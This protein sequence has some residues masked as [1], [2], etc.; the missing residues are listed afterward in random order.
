MGH[1]DYWQEIISFIKEYEKKDINKK[2]YNEKYICCFLSIWNLK[3]AI[4]YKCRRV[5]LTRTSVYF[6]ISNLT[7]PFSYFI[8]VA[9]MHYTFGLLFLH[10]TLHVSFL[11]D[12]SQSKTGV[13]NQMSRLCFCRRSTIVHLNVQTA[14]AEKETLYTFS[15]IIY[16]KF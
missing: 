1:V 10:C 12:R 11:F 5:V 4:L 14:T 8:H 13:V 2:E 7:L 3:S 9:T 15:N 6:F 16:I